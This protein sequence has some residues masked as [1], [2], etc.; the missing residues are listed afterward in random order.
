MFEMGKHDVMARNRTVLHLDIKNPD[1]MK[2][3]RELIASADGLVEGFRPGVMEK[4]ALGPDDCSNRMQRLGL[5]GPGGAWLR[6]DATP[7]IS[8]ELDTEIDDGLL[9]QADDAMDYAQLLWDDYVISRND[10]SGL[11]SSRGGLTA[12]IARLLA[13]ASIEHCGTSLGHC[14]TSL[15]HCGTLLEHCSTLLE[16]CDTFAA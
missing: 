3:I 12:G 1:D 10:S 15:A 14:G 9:A 4:L 2:T 5:A 8:D 11:L 7:S 6:L 16:H 13:L